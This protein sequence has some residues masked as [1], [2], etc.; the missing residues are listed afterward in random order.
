MQ[1]PTSNFDRRASHA[2]YT[3]ASDSLD[4]ICLLP[5][6]VRD[7]DQPGNWTLCFVG[8]DGQVVAGAASAQI[9]LLVDSGRFGV[10]K[11]PRTDADYLRCRHRATSVTYGGYLVRQAFFERLHSFR[12]DLVQVLALCLAWHRQPAHQVIARLLSGNQQQLDALWLTITTD[13]AAMLRM[14]EAL[15]SIE[16]ASA[17]VPG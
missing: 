15:R 1:A 8:L 9:T 4:A 7:A 5:E 12:S 16:R 13:T 3:R 6:F 11:L 10:V 17:A 14:R 2:S